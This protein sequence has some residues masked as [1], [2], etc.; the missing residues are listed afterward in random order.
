VLAA[1]LSRPGEVVTRRELAEQVWGSETFVDFEQGLNFA[2][3][4]I[5]SVLGDDAEQ[6]R[7]LETVPKRGYR[8]IATLESPAESVPEA[9]QASAA[10]SPA[11]IAAAEKPR[12]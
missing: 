5:R 9:M 4:H 10:I 3:R 12:S 7:F 11:T 1:L 2:I 8:F 6:P